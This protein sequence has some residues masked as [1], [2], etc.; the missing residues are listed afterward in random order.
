M[1][2]KI[3]I[4]STEYKNGLWIV[5]VYVDSSYAFRCFGRTRDIAEANAQ[6]AAKGY[7]VEELVEAIQV[8]LNDSTGLKMSTIKTINN[9]ITKAAQP[10]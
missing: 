7:L 9:A 8:C 1:E 3:E 6:I 5:S 2:K 10:I 4:G